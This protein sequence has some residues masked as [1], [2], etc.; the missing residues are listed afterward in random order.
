MPDDAAGA[1]TTM[2]SLAEISRSRNRAYG[3]R[4]HHGRMSLATEVPGDMNASGMLGNT[5][6]A[7]RHCWHPLASS[8]EVTNVPRR[9]WLLG[10][11]WVAVR[12]RTGLAVLK[13]RCPHRWAP[14]SAGSVIDGELQCSYH[15]WRFCADG[16]ASLIPSLGE[17]ATLPPKARAERPFDVVERFGLVFVAVEQPIVELPEADGVRDTPEE[18]TRVV[19]LGP[20]EGRYG[21]ALLIDNQI[22]VTHFA[23]LHR[24][25]F[26]ADEA[27]RIPAY[28]LTRLPWGFSFDLTVPITAGNDPEVEKN[29]HPLTQYRDMSYRYHV[30]FHLSLTLSYPVMGG[31]NTIVFWAQPQSADQC[32]FYIT[33]HMWQPGGFTEAELAKRV[34]FEERVVGEDLALQQ[35]FAD[36]AIPLVASAE[37][38]VKSDKA[39]LEYR[40]LLRALVSEAASG[41]RTPPS[42]PAAIDAAVTASHAATAAPS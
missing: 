18:E 17:G 25:T 24:G 29:R 32:R 21:A 26:G 30:P 13:D 20:Y 40:R 39:S 4:G 38:H 19:Q 8:D 11:P 6:D 36:L 41:L 16:G 28:D 34:A 14:L 22:D 35:R 42:E 3:S 9:F 12:L 1:K 5:H 10:E 27:E 23:F 2:A 37:C 15:G 33:M 7:L 31:S